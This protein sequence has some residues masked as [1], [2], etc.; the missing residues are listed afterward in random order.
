[1]LSKMYG[2][3][4]CLIMDLNTIYLLLLRYHNIYGPRMG[5][6]HVIP[7]MIEKISKQK[8]IEV[9]SPQ[10][11]RSM[12][13]IDDA[14]EMTIRACES[15]ITNKE[16]L[17]IGNQDQE[18]SIINLTKLIASILNKNIEIKCLPNTEGSPPRRCRIL[19]KFSE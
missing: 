4:S 14:I 18:I 8:I 1:M 5:F 6:L 19:Q 3:Q 9:A 10:H 17:N 13:F 7:E 16:I 11:T 15:N 2:N 12:C